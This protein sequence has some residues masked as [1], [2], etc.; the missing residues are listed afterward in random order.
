M[1]SITGGKRV[2]VDSLKAFLY[3]GEGDNAPI[4]K[5]YSNP[6]TSIKALD[7][8]SLLASEINQSYAP[9]YLEYDENMQ[10]IIKNYNGAYDRSS[11]LANNLID[12]IITE[13]QK[14]KKSSKFDH[15]FIVNGLM[16][17]PELYSSFLTE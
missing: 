2:L 9:S 15:Y 11:N 17:D 3:D 13:L 5:L 6:D 1:P 10:P 8:E 16:L 12:F 4:V 7:I 14:T